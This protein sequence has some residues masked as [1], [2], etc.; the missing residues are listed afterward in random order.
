[1][2][3]RAGQYCFLCIPELSMFEW[4]PFSISTSPYNDN[5]NFTL[6]VRVLGDW[7]ASLKQ[8]ALK[9]KGV[10][11][12]FEGPYGEPQVDIEGS[13]Y[14]MFL[15]ISG[16]IGITPMQSICNQLLDE[17]A[18]GRPLD[19]CYFVWSCRDKD[20]VESVLPSPLASSTA[21]SSGAESAETGAGRNRSL[22]MSFQPNL[23]KKYSVSP[24]VVK[25][26]DGKKDFGENGILEEDD[27]IHTEFYLTK[28]KNESELRDS[29]VRDKAKSVLRYGRPDIENLFN[30]MLSVA[31]EKGV[32]R[33]A[34]LTCGPAGLV[35][36]VVGQAQLLNLKC[37]VQFDVHK[38]TF[39]F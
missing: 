32:R 13:K 17:H 29:N 25:K 27:T 4:H 8:L 1:M 21:T 14:T 2:N 34:V 23:L 6:H 36:S 35:A 18:R 11:I 3:Y 16:G 12:L 7:T 20:M 31:K 5:G 19:L 30:T 24:M 9:K 26:S 39:A 10:S 15:L 33:V 28:A 38:E 37:G 22:P